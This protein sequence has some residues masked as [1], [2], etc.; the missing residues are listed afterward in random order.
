MLKKLLKLAV[1]S[2]AI[3]CFVS[4]AAVTPSP[5]MMAQFKNLPAAEQ[6]KLAKQYGIN[7]PAGMNQTSSAEQLGANT[8]V[9]VPKGSA[10]FSGSALQQSTNDV[11]L[12][13]PD[14]PQRFGMNLFSAQVSTFA[15]V[16]NA[17][18]ADSYRL[19]PDDTLLVQLYGKNNDSYE[20][21]ISRDGTVNLSDIGPVAIGGLSFSEASELI[22]SKISEA[23]LGV[24]AAISMGKLRTINVFV[25]GEAKNPGM[26][27]VSAMTS[28]TQALYL[29]GGVSDIGSLR[30]IQIKRAGKTVGHFDLYD[31]LLRGDSSAD[32]LLRHGDVVF[33]APIKG[34]AQALGE[35]KRP[36]IYEIASGENLD[37]LL[38][39]A[40]GAAAGAYPQ[41][42]VLERYNS[43]NLR[44]LLNLDLTKAENRKIPLRDGDILRIAETSPRIEN[45]ITLAGAVVRPGLYAWQ[46]GQRINNLISSFWSDLLLTVDLDYALVVRETNNVGDVKVIQ[47]NLANAVNSPASADNV[48]LMPRDIVLIFHHAD[49][50]YQRAELNSYLRKQIEQ[51]LQSTQDM[52]W[53]ATEDLAK[54]AFSQL[55]RRTELHREAAAKRGVSQFIAG[56]QIRNRASMLDSMTLSAAGDQD[57]TAD[58]SVLQLAQRNAQVQAN[59]TADSSIINNAVNEVVGSKALPEEMARVM[60]S[61]YYDKDLLSLSASL[62]RTELL[63]PLVERLRVQARTGE[64]ALLVRVQGE[65]R[66]PGEYP[67]VEHADVSSLV[68]AAGGFT[69]AAYLGRAEITRAVAASAHENGIEVENISV[70]LQAAFNG[71]Q[72][73]ALQSRDRLNVFPI[74]NWNI[75]Q[76][77]EVRGEVRFPGRYTIKRGEKLSDVI[78][79][80]GG[81][82]GNA[83]AEGA[84]YTRDSVRERERLQLKKL[85]EQLRSDIATKSLTAD[86]SLGGGM[87]ASAQE[88]LLMI[89]QIEK[90]EPVGRLVLDLDAV[91]ASE[92]TADIQVEDGDLLYIPRSD[93]TVSVVGEV[94]HASSHRYKEGLTLQDY[95]DLAGGM[96][97]RA[98]KERVY[99]IKANGS[100][101]IPSTSSWFAVAQDTLQPGDTIVVPVDTEY[102]DNLSLWTAVTQIFYQ[103]AV[104]IAAINSF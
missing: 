81:L 44:D 73:F 72:S 10:N 58:Q 14:K 55:L 19:G 65:V 68:M 46:Q 1:S 100:V 37:T 77:V 11:L 41:A 56:Q 40:G 31:L 102:K 76:V 52:Q 47:F 97:K 24:D 23:M 93:F 42:V 66:V 6:Q 104:A 79:R 5:A 22:K 70:D 90:Q 38:S 17:P 34:T 59:Q 80:A 27:S 61:L 67:L 64:S 3:L 101:Q 75:D 12:A 50:T 8:E 88:S 32:I 86:K 92:S 96:R 13:D 82:T 25:A 2:V 91:I 29:A 26:Y 63:Y 16:D 45:V 9:L 21:I 18:V 28:V 33:V 48:A 98:D 4:Q 99:V 39:M 35:V 7:L 51:R 89:E 95:L 15:P 85:S 36:A 71:S 103:S 62:T 94:Q 57:P 30:N 49:Q 54:K 87:A 60:R 69:E 84:I 53:A 74:P 78:V 83:F 43:N 20:L